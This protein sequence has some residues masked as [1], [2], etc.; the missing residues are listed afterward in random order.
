MDLSEIIDALGKI[1]DSS[2]D[3]DVSHHFLELVKTGAEGEEVTIRGNREGLIYL[4]LQCLDLAF[5]KNEGSHHHFDE[6]EMLDSA[7]AP[8]VI[9]YKSASWEIK[10]EE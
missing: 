6:I 7:E 8:L 3:C 9:A 1:D 10:N 5:R 2:I 4:A